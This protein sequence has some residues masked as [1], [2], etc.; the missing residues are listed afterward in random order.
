MIVKMIL[1]FWRIILKLKFFVIFTYRKG[2][3]LIKEDYIILFLSVRDK[4]FM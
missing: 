2:I 1:L 3:R 4:I